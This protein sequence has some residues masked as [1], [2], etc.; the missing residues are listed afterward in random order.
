MRSSKVSS[1][2][3]FLVTKKEEEKVFLINLDI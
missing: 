1:K 2:L 3:I